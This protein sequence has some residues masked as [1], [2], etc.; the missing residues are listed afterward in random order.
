[1]SH[2]DRIARPDW[3]HRRAAAAARV[4]A[5][6][7]RKKAGIAVLRIPTQIGPF[8]DQLIEDKFLA[9]WDTENIPAI[10]RAAVEMHRVYGLGANAL[11]KPRD[12]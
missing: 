1:M 6:K 3:R 4:R 9:E 8:A 11:P 5:S 12:R 10:E 2:A 7:L